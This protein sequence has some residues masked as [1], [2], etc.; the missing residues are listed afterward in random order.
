MKITDIFKNK[1]TK[2]EKAII[3]VDKKQLEKIVG[4]IDSTTTTTVI[5]DNGSTTDSIKQGHY[6]VSNFTSTDKTTS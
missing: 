6:A 3:K 1:K 5:I 4:G 2:N